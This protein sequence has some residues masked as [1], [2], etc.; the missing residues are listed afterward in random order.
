MYQA[1]VLLVLEVAHDLG[2]VDHSRVL[3]ATLL[4]L[5]V[6]RHL[7]AHTTRQCHNTVQA[8]HTKLG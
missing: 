6:V 1:D 4:K 8:T 7:I 5:A 2:I 3:A